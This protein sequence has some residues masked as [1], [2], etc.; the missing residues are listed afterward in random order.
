MK[1]HKI[2]VF[3]IID[4]LNLIFNEN[5]YADN[6][7]QNLLKRDKRWG[8]SDRAFIAETTYDMVSG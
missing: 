4:G 8:A 2:L 5:E 1:L 3:A 6:V 7:V